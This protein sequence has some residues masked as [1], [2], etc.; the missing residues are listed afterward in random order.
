ML[1][2]SFKSVYL[3]KNFVDRRLE[4]LLEVCMLH[5]ESTRNNLSR[6]PCIFTTSHHQ[7]LMQLLTLLPISTTPCKLWEMKLATKFMHLHLGGKALMLPGQRMPS[8]HERKKRWLEVQWQRSSSRE[9]A[10]WSISYAPSTN[11]WSMDYQP[12]SMRLDLSKF[13]RTLPRWPSELEQGH[14]KWHAFLMV[15]SRWGSHIAP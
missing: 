9:E 7:Y 8:S 12:C 1:L 10:W 11:S 2:S 15:R 6:T 13:H 4:S 3:R 14:L 5:S